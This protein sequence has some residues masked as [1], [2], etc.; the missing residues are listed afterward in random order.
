MPHYSDYDVIELY[1]PGEFNCKYKTKLDG[2]VKEIQTIKYPTQILKSFLNGEYKTFITLEPI[3]LYRVF[4]MF[5]RDD[6]K[7]TNNGAKLNGAFA[8]TEFA[9]SIIDAKVRLALNPEWMN[10][11]MYEAKIIVPKDIIIS[12]GVVA[13]VVLKTKTVLAGGADQILLPKDWS[14]DWI[15]GY[16]RITSRQLQSEPVFVNDKP[17]KYNKKDELYSMICPC[18][19]GTNIE[20][21]DE[22]NRITVYG[23]RGGVYKMKYHCLN[24]KC[25]YYW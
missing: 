4:G 21:L 16:R 25:D 19:R 3:V 12:V 5:L 14:E 17:P 7:K 23:K 22:S 2:K 20:Q 9:E 6:G 13:P 15:V 18:C 10:T 8:S 24:A 11:K 1:S